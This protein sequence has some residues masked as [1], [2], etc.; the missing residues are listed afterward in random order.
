MK[1]EPEQ[2]FVVDINAIGAP[3]T[4]IKVTPDG[5]FYWE[6]FNE[7]SAQH[8]DPTQGQVLDRELADFGGV[9]KDN[10]RLLKGAIGEFRRCVES[11]FPFT[12]EAKYEQDD[13]PSTWVQNTFTPIFGESGA[14]E[15]I[16]VTSIDITE[17]AQGNAGKAR[18]CAHPSAQWLR[19][20]LRHLQGH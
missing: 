5:R 6:A 2:G 14:V 8:M 17:L 13:G 7:L 19:D 20:D 10:I 11:R 1:T 15:K 12:S 9:S 18:E 4:I 3:I 16:L